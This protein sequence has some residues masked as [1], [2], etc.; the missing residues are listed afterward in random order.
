MNHTFN[1]TINSTINSTFN[2]TLNPR[3]NPTS[4]Y[5]SK[6]GDFII[7]IGI[8]CFVLICLRIKYYKN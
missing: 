7:F 1:T 6:T 3:I 2:T 8:I 5:K 4:F